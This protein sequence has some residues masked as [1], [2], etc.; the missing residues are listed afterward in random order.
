MVVEGDGWKPDKFILKKGVPVHW[1]INGKEVLSCNG[2]IQVPKYNLEFKINPGEQ[3]IEFTPTESGVIPWSCWMGMIKGTFIVKENI[4]LTN[5]QEV[6]KELDSVQTP[7][8]GS[9]G[10]SSGGCGCGCGGGGCG[11]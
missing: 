7:E 1:I 11:G 3:I 5:P 6:K 4:D 10:G 2:G 8:G 9:C